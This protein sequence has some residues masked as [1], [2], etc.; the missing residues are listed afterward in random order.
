MSMNRHPAR[1]PRLLSLK[2]ISELTTVP[3]STLYTLLARGE[4]PAVRLGKSL[5]IDERDLLNWIAD[6]RE[7]A[8]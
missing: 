4:L 8:K 6:H 5:R 7:V 3:R 2:V 1:V